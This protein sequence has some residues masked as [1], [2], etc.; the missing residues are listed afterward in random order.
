MQ[1]RDNGGRGI[2]EG[3]RR[4]EERERGL[5]GL[6]GREGKGK[7]ALK[8][9]GGEGKTGEGGAPPNKYL[10]LHHWCPCFWTQLLN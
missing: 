10:P 7:A 6:E 4:R 1:G 2:T 5:K 3:G 8:G 9:Q